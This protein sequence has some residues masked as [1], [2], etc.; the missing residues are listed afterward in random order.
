MESGR[1][2]IGTWE[3][4]KVTWFRDRNVLD[5]EMEVWTFVDYDAGFAGLWDC[6]FCGH[7]IILSSS[8]G[9]EYGLDQ[10]GR[11]SGRLERV[12]KQ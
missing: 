3:D 12:F 9:P 10:K 6:C 11:K 2:L 5:F 4:G 7:D 1:V 8:L